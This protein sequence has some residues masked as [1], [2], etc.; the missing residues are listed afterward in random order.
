MRARTYSTGITTAVL[1]VNRLNSAA[2][3]FQ[4]YK[5]MNVQKRVSDLE[6][7]DTHRVRY[8]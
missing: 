1:T 5:F 8:L 3:Y 6:I 7:T 2:T 4:T